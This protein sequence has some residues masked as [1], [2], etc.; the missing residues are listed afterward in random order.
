MN[1]ISYFEDKMYGLIDRMTD[2]VDQ[3]LETETGLL[4]W[5]LNKYTVYGELA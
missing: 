2:A 5:F 1:Q 3:A 4:Y